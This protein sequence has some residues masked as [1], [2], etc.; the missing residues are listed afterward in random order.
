MDHL[1]HGDILWQN[2]IGQTSVTF[3][4]ICQFCDKM[5]QKEHKRKYYQIVWHFVTCFTLHL[6]SL[7]LGHVFY[8]HA[9]FVYTCM[10][11]TTSCIIACQCFLWRKKFGQRTLLGDS[12]TIGPFTVLRLVSS[13]QCNIVSSIILQ[14]HFG[15]SFTFFQIFL[16][17]FRVFSVDL[18]RV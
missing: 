8:D 10:W 3:C 9:V 17:N 16:L 5:W 15:Q 18:H 6:H 2:L 1:W 11:P 12:L 4:D 7:T 14:R 13:G